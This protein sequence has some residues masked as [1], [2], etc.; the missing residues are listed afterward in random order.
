MGTGAEPY[1]GHGKVREGAHGEGAGVPDSF[2]ADSQADERID[3]TRPRIGG[4]LPAASEIIGAGV[5]AGRHQISV[6][7]VQFISAL[8]FDLA[9]PITN[10]QMLLAARE[11]GLKAKAVGPE[12]QVSR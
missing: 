11:L 10:A 1:R 8:G 2:C 5:L 7:P 6:H 3:D 12:A 4:T 9:A